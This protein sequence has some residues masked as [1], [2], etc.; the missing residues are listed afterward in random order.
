M[1]LDGGYPETDL[2]TNVAWACMV[3]NCLQ[4]VYGYSPNQLE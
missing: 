2:D 1:R 4:N 3:K